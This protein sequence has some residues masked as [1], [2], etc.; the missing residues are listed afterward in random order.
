MVV[1]L[2]TCKL[3]HLLHIRAKCV[4]NTARLLDA[5]RAKPKNC[6]ARAEQI[7]QVMQGMAT[8]ME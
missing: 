6:P 1:L 3:S 8:R 5:G 4:C 7:V 2:E